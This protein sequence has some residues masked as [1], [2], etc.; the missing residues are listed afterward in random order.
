[1]GEFEELER[2]RF[3]N[4]PMTF[5]MARM[6][7]AQYAICGQC[8]FWENSMNKET[9]QCEGWGSCEHEDNLFDYHHDENPIPATFGCI[10]WQP[11]T[12]EAT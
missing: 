2:K 7:V 12:D 5:E 1:M 8:K 4:N 11:R 6:F 10:H 9:H 3:T